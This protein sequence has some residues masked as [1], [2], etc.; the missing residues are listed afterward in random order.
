M[1]TLPGSET[2]Q[3]TAKEQA[4]LNIIKQENAIVKVLD[5]YGFDFLLNQMA[6]PDMHRPSRSLYFYNQRVKM[7]RPTSVL[8]FNP[9]T[10][11]RHQHTFGHCYDCRDAQ[12]PSTRGLFRHT[13]TKKTTTSF[14]PTDPR[15]M[16]LYS[17]A[18]PFAFLWDINAC[19]KKDER[20]M[21]GNGDEAPWIDTD[22]CE[23]LD[24][25][26]KKET[27]PN[28][29]Y[30][31]LHRDDIATAKT[32]GRTTPLH[33]H[34]SINR[35]AVAEENRIGFNEFL[36]G[37]PKK[38][39][40]AICHVVDADMHYDAYTDT[41]KAH[42]YV[43]YVMLYVKIKFGFSDDIP[44]LIVS[45]TTP[46]RAY[47]KQNMHHDLKALVPDWVESEEPTKEY[48]ENKLFSG[49]SDYDV[50]MSGFVIVGNN[51]N[52]T[53]SDAARKGSRTSL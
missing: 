45:D 7:D 49:Y 6:D 36:I 52:S 25:R 35:D 10:F 32:L 19:D 44:V 29:S 13:H 50:A 37:V 28:A 18:G 12:P 43:W 3:L 42:L 8:K 5:P 16:R 51:T 17:A 23:W 48:L 14:L 15:Y 22:D 20:Y 21:F 53:K 41:P 24:V 33:V 9:K 27:D 38:R 40:D 1:R 11:A 4:A 46:V 2:G 34:R 39:V 26:D 31:D 47:T 30:Y